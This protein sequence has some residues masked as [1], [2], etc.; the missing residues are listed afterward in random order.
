MSFFITATGTD[1][2][3][4]L[5]TGLLARQLSA[6]GHAVTLRKPIASGCD[7]SGGD[8]ALLAA[9]LG[10]HADKLTL[11]RI[12]PWR[13]TAPLSPPIAAKREGMSL[14]FEAITTFCRVPHAGTLLIEGAGGVMSPLTENH[15]I[16]DLAT[17]LRFPV[18]LACGTYL[19]AISHTLSALEVIRARG[20]KL[21]GIVLSASAGE[22]PDMHD[23]AAAIATLSG[24]GAPLL[25]LPR[26]PLDGLPVKTHDERMRYWEAAL[27]HAPDLT[28]LCHDG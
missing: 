12:C 11:D 7:D 18:I 19:G 15:T 21:A 24:S 6:H 10:Q 28:G 14:S 27:R 8:G 16:L 13:L 25:A 4:T 17:T 3:K 26:L 22:H 9:A 5:I 20:L 2:G 23:T 1:A